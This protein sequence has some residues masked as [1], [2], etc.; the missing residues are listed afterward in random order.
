MMPFRKEAREGSFSC[1]LAATGTMGIDYTTPTQGAG[2]TLGA[3]KSISY[4]L[5]GRHYIY[6]PS[7]KVR[8]N[9]IEA[10]ARDGI[11]IT[12]EDRVTIEGRGGRGIGAGRRPLRL[13]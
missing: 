12:G 1:L 11:A 5:I 7:A 2:A 9:G 4:D 13:C 3:G 10:N 6:V 8:I